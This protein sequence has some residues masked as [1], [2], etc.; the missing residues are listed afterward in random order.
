[1]DGTGQTRSVMVKGCDGV[2]NVVLDQVGVDGD[3]G[4]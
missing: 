2:V 1:M 3:G 4:G